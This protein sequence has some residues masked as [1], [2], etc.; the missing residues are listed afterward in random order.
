MVEHPESDYADEGSGSQ[1]D[2]RSRP[3]PTPEKL[4]R[5]DGIGI[6]IVGAV[7]FLACVW[8]SSVH[9]PRPVVHDEFSYLLAGD[10]FAHGRLSNPT[11]RAWQHFETMH[12]LL[13]PNYASK[14]P[15]GQGMVLAL[16][17]LV[18]GQPIFGVWLSMAAAAMCVY[19]MLAAWLERPWAL[20]GALAIALHPRIVQGW[21]DTYWGGAVALAGG[22]LLYGAFARLR[23]RPRPVA[24]TGLAIGLG[25]LAISRPFEGLVAS[26][27]V[28]GVL[29]ID[30]YRWLRLQPSYPT[31]DL[32]KG[33]ALLFVLLGAFAV[34][35]ALHNKAVTGS[36]LRFPYVEYSEQY[37]IAPPFVL[38]SARPE[39]TY[40]N[41]DLRKFFKRVSNDH[42][43]R[44]TASGFFAGVYAKLNSAF[45][46]FLGWG[47]A[48]VG[49][50][51]LL[52][53]RKREVRFAFACAA[54]FVVASSA[55]TF[56]FHHY[57]A[58]F[59]P[60][61][62]YLWVSGLRAI[63]HA[64][65]ASAPIRI[66]AV[67]VVLA[68]FA[69]QADA[70]NRA[71][72]YRASFEIYNRDNVVQW[73]EKRGGEHLVIVRYGAKHNPHIEWVQNEA[74]L[75]N[76][77]VVWA[78]ELS[79]DRAKSLVAEFPERTAWLYRPDIDPMALQKY[80]AESD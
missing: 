30:L 2:S 9:P 74:D 54:G 20:V 64:N 27:P 24:I 72:A 45:D 80:P 59:V 5:H 13:E 58:P 75:E 44:R 48:V 19:W 71:A 65:G 21:G 40:D 68:S 66:G 43:Q 11:P 49:L 17:Q 34:F 32:L 61:G 76:A 46:F 60:I 15:A 39:P 6:L 35:T 31:P 3:S 25:L 42:A 41:P 53:L 37:E 51:A 33:G 77:R 67:L 52:A 62:V 36:A 69:Q 10:T 57:L 7:A 70:A 63:W 4:N 50:G 28:L 16:G 79:P 29:A 55:V 18:A 14:Y 1:S 26:I 38:Q 47:F 22:A 8:V 23:E 56:D 73:F 78:R 12:T